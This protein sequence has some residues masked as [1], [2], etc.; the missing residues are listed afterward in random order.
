MNV[1]ALEASWAEAVTLTTP[2][3]PGVQEVKAASH[4]PAQPAPLGA[5]FRMEVSLELKVNVAPMLLPAELVADAEKLTK[6]PT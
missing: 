5:M 2:V 3:P 4:R 6:L 1:G